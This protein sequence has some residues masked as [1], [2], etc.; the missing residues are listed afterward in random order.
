MTTPL[1]ARR[2]QMKSRLVAIPEVIDAEFVSHDDDP[3]PY[4]YERLLTPEDV[5]SVLRIGR[6]R[7]YELLNAEVL[8]SVKIGKS[9]R[10]RRADLDEFIVELAHQYNCR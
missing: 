7:V 5:A 3:I 10:I 2:N 6:T 4:H 9:R 8:R 1:P